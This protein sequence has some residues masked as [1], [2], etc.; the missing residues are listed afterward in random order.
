MPKILSG[1]WYV[2]TLAVV[3]LQKWFAPKWKAHVQLNARMK[4]HKRK[5]DKTEMAAV[6]K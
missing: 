1:L 4:Y 3:K 2:V 5:L 6:S